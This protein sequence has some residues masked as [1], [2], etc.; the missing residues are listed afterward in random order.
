MCIF[1]YTDNKKTGALTHCGPRLRGIR[2][3]E[4]KKYQNIQSLGTSGE[5]FVIMRMF[6]LL[7]DVMPQDQSKFSSLQTFSRDGSEKS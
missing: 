4:R 1:K 2:R 6:Y 5:S 3:Q 7:E